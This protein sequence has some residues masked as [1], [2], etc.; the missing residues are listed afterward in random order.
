[1]ATITPYA[2]RAT[3]TADS[4]AE[5]APWSADKLDAH[6]TIAAGLETIRT[7]L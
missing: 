2:D 1:V 6:A 3:P 4:N 5:H 7:F